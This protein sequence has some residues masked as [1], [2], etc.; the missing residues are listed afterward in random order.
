MSTFPYGA[1]TRFG[2]VACC[3]DSSQWR[4]SHLILWALACE[5]CHAT[6]P[7]RR[8]TV[9]GLFC[10]KTRTQ[11]LSTSEFRVLRLSDKFSFQPANQIWK[12]PV[13][14]MLRNIVKRQ[15]II[16]FTHVCCMRFVNKFVQKRPVSWHFSDLIRVYSQHG[17]NAKYK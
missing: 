5:P 4:G 2:R 9:A 14:K 12:F 3:R 6:R 11:P 16:I 17:T 1:Q 13:P 15:L 7:Q 10:S 8:R